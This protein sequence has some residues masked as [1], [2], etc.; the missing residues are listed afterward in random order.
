MF[1]PVVDVD[2]GD[3][4]DQELEFALVEDVDKVGGNQFVEACDEGVE[5]LF[6]ALFD[7]PF[8]EE[9]VWGDLL[10]DTFFI[11]RMGRGEKLTPHIRACSRL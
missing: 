7:L 9:P 8:G 3:T 4:A 5:L 11:G 2:V 1:L 10:A 6:Y